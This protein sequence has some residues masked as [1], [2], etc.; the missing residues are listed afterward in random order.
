MT[1]I[2]TLLSVAIAAFC[3]ELFGCDSASARQTDELCDKIERIDSAEFFRNMQ[4]PTTLMPET[5]D[6]STT[7]EKKYGQIKVLCKDSVFVFKDDPSD[8][9]FFE[10]SIAGRDFNNKWVLV[11]GQDYSQEYYFWVNCSTNTI[12]TLV[13]YPI[14]FGDR[15]LC[16]E[17]SYTDGL[18]IIEIWTYENNVLQLIDTFSFLPCDIF[19][20]NESYLKDD[21]LFVNHDTDQFLKLRIKK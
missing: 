14:R 9:G 1:K 10:Y 8:D 5:L 4:L 3:G 18:S 13:G 21:Y 16:V 12:D 6:T 15:Y 19:F 7:I 2:L 20:I 17:G 11:Q